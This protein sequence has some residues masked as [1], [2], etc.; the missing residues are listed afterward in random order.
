MTSLTRV[1][2]TAT[3]ERGQP[4]LARLDID[5]AELRCVVRDYV[6][7]MIRSGRGGSCGLIT[8]LGSV[9]DIAG[10]QWLL[11][12]VERGRPRL[13]DPERLGVVALLGRRREWR[14][15]AD[16]RSPF[17]PVVCDRA[18]LGVGGGAR[19]FVLSRSPRGEVDLVVV[20]PGEP[21]ERWGLGE[22]AGR[23]EL[24]A[25]G[26]TLGFWSGAR[27]AIV[28]LADLVPGG[29]PLTDPR[30]VELPL[31]WVALPSSVVAVCDLHDRVVRV[32]ERH[33]DRW[34][35]AMVE[36]DDQR[37]VWRASWPIERPERWLAAGGSLWL[38]A[39]EVWTRIDAVHGPSER[40]EALAPA[41]S[42]AAIE[43]D[44]AGR[45]WLWLC[46][47]GELLRVDG[48]TLAA[49]SIERW[50]IP[51][52]L[53]VSRL[54]VSRSSGAT[55]PATILHADELAELLALAPELADA[56]RG[57]FDR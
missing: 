6:D 18:P 14:G 20:R 55:D 46:E 53:S 50:T 45:P 16:E 40:S 2:V 31:R 7:P 33:G 8:A 49:E 54:L 48:L 25:G 43:L 56:W 52:E 4:K 38:A 30:D 24:L 37:A 12:A 21:I 41:I 29:C 51:A 32:I 17:L 34:T 13:I 1:F 28:E 23:V 47:R 19:D 39:G 36:I 44:H 27:L 35:I 15:A 9:V 11:A 26:G 22:H 57:W 42:P 5:G 3:A 10:G